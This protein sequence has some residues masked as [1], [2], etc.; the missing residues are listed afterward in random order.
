MKSPATAGFA[1]SVKLPILR[2]GDRWQEAPPV[3]PVGRSF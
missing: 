2:F 3:F 1:N